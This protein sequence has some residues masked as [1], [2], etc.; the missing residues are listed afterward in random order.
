MNETVS[1]VNKRKTEEELNKN[2]IFVG[3]EKDF[4][5]NPCKANWPTLFK[6]N[7]ALIQPPFHSARLT[8]N[9]RQLKS[10]LVTRHK[11]VNPQNP[12]TCLVTSSLNGEGVTTVAFNLAS[13]FSLDHERITILIDASG[14]DR[15]LTAKLGLNHLKGLIDFLEGGCSVQSIIYPLP[16]PRLFLIP[17]GNLNPCRSEYFDSTLMRA[18][19][20]S[21]KDAFPKSQLI[22]DAPAC[23][24]EAECKV[25]SQHMESVLFV[26]Q[27]LKTPQHILKQSL[28]MIDHKK[29]A[30]IIANNATIIPSKMTQQV[31]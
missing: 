21:L 8:A 19:F 27:V 12:L 20:D 26:N 23:Y 31:T 1:Q 25:L 3:S 7:P 28:E 15:S 22:I 24:Q 6:D 10:T 9:F 30:G 29:I 11:K 13:C 16:T 17:H 2:K 4:N 14:N 5:R 18:L